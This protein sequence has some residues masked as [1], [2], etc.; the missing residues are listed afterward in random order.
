M[1]D[2]PDTRDAITKGMQMTLLA[3]FLGWMMD[4]YEQALF[5]PLA[6]PALKSMVPA[7]IAALGVKALNG[8]VGGWRGI[9]TA[10]LLVGAARGGAA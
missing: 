2:A 1:H 5:P 8:W 9:M 6:G 3:G 4:G 7:D 10:A